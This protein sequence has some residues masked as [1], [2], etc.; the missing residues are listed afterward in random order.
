[1]RLQF[2]EPCAV[3]SSRRRDGS[4]D[5]L[6]VNMQFAKYRHM[7]T[8]RL[9]SAVQFTGE[10]REETRAFFEKPIV[11]RQGKFFAGEPIGYVVKG[12][13]LLKNQAGEIRK[14]TNVEFVK[15]YWP[16]E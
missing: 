3:H 9:V 11:I 1:M 13:W 12:D 10:N 15:N 4:S 14:R 7:V 5:T 8:D 16:A 6:E 2:H